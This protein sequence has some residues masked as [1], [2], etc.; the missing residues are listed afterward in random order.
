M[1]R[2]LFACMLALNAIIFSTPRSD[3][4]ITIGYATAD[5]TMAKAAGF[6]FAE[7]RIR[8]FMKL[9]DGD[10]DKFVMECHATDLPLT[11][12]YWLFPAELM[13]VGPDVRMDALT[14]YLVKA[15][16]RSQRLGVKFVVWGSG[17]A[18]RAP[19]GFS[20]ARAFDQ[21]V[22]LGRF[23]APEAQRRGMIIVAEPLRRQESNTIN[24]A[25]EGLQWVEAVDHPGFQLLVDLF[26][27]N[28]VHEDAAIIVKAGAHIVHTHVS[29]P[30]G[31]VLP[32]SAD[33]FDY[34]PYFKAL[35]RIGYHGTMTVETT[36]VDIPR[37]GAKSIQFLRAAYAAAG[38]QVASEAP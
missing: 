33:E 32:L 16:D 27:M 29:N 2:V 9:S 35:N 19:E 34:A 26:H 22:A 8:E 20:K 14:S 4:T 7:V 3:S 10:F 28:E 38:R 18:R 21:L 5:F 15:L 1:T 13:V 30:I 23:L 25:A 17:D 6:E 31:R 11:T 36:A 12:G 24:S 37:D